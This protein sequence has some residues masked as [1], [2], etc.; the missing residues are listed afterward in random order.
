MASE[1]DVW[2]RRLFRERFGLKSPGDCKGVLLLVRKGRC[3]A[4]GRCV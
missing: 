3:V 1:K 4:G 2:L